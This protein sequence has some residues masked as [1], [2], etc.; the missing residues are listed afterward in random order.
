MNLKKKVCSNEWLD[1]IVI[2]MIRLKLTRINLGIM[3]KDFAP[4]PQ[5]LFKQ[6]RVQCISAIVNELKASGVAFVSFHHNEH[7]NSI[8]QQNIQTSDAICGVETR[9]ERRRRW[10]WED[11]FFFF[12]Y[13]KFMIAN[14]PS[15]RLMEKFSE[16]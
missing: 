9:I 3:R 6:K 10:R 5:S 1:K 4:P 12:L 8:L 2:K 15:G 11:I 14:I 16:Q 13:W 7:K